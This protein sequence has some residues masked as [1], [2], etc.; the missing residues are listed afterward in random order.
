VVQAEY[1]ELQ[2]LRAFASRRTR[3]QAVATCGGDNL[4]GLRAALT[5]LNPTVPFAKQ[6]LSVIGNTVSSG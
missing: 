1:R 5:G 6:L 4:T 3:D 2:R